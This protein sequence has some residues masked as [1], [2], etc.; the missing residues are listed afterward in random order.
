[1]EKGEDAAEEVR[2]EE[3]NRGGMVTCD[4]CYRIEMA[5]RTE[6]KQEQMNASGLWWCLASTMLRARKNIQHQASSI[7]VAWQLCIH[8]DPIKMPVLQPT[9]HTA[10]FD[11]Q[12]TLSRG[13]RASGSCSASRSPGSARICTPVPQAPFQCC[14]PASSSQSHVGLYRQCGHCAGAIGSDHQHTIPA[15]W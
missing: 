3:R 13:Y 7:L 10:E 4:A 12:T 8:R 9:H 11:C 2:L 14:K 1:V 15:V 6:I 5:R